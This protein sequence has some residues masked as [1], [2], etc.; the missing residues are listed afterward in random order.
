MVYYASMERSEIIAKYPP[1]RDCL[2][3]ILHELQ[4]AGDSN[5]LT[6][7]DLQAAA[8]YL[9]IPYSAVYGVATYYSMYSLKPRGRHVIRVCKSPVC[10]MMG[11]PKVTRRLKDLLGIGV[12]ET[13][14]DGSFTLEEAAC[15]GRCDSGPSMMIDDEYFGALDEA[16]LISIIQ[17]FRDDR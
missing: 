9:N 3:L 15:L 17:R 5:S 8:A 16:R 10:D 14:E 4:N 12:G 13:T 11:G 2:L 7:S 6:E 1:E